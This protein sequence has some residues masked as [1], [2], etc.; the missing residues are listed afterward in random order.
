M[1]ILELQSFTWWIIYPV[2]AICASFLVYK[3]LYFALFSECDNI[4]L[5]QYDIYESEPHIYLVTELLPDGDLFD[6][7]VKNRC[8]P[9][10]GVRVS[11]IQSTSLYCDMYYV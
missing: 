10:S 4:H 11:L 8:F 2:F 6:C 3:S 5:L 1:F 7:I 9:E